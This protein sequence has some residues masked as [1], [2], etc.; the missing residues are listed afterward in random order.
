[1]SNK[2]D[3][4]NQAI[5]IRSTVRIVYKDYHGQETERS[6]EPLEWVTH[7]RIRA[8][9][10][11]RGEERDFRID[12]IVECALV[13]TGQSQRT[14][15]NKTTSA[16]ADQRETLQPVVHKVKPTDTRKEPARSRKRLGDQPIAQVR[17]ADQWSRLVK[18]YVECLVRENQ[19]QYIIEDRRGACFFFPAKPETVRD[20][21]EGRVFLEF[22]SGQPSHPTPVARFVN[23]DAGRQGQ[24]LCLGYPVLVLNDEKIAPLI[25]APVE[26]QESNGKLR[27]QAQDPEPSYAVFRNQGLSAEEIEAVLTAYAAIGSER[28]QFQVEAWENL[29][30]GQISQMTG[31]A[32]RRRSWNG[33][34]PVP[35]EPGTLCDAPLLFWVKDNVATR[36]LIRE[37]RDLSAHGKWESAPWALRELLS[38]V[39]EKEYPD[40]PAPRDDNNVYVAEANDRQRQA[41]TAAWSTR[42]TVVTG[43]PGTGKSQMVLNLIAQAV[44]GD[45]SV[46]FAS[47]NNKAVDV[48]MDRLKNEIRFPGAVRT[49]NTSNRQKAAEDMALV[50][51]RISVAGKPSSVAPLREQ[52]LELGK[53]LADAAETLHQVRELGGLLD[54]HLAERDDLI[55]LLPKPVAEVAQSHPPKYQREEIHHLRMVISNLLTTALKIRDEAARLEGDIVR[56]VKQNHLR[57]PILD[58]LA[59]FEDQWG[60]F[61][62][63]FLD[64]RELDTLEAIQDY[65]QTWL[66]LL[67]ALEAQGQITQL[68]HRFRELSSS[69]SQRQSELHIELQDQVEIAASRVENRALDSFVAE[70]RR[71]CERSAAIAR[72]DLSLWDKLL[73]WVGLK[74]PVRE[75]GERFLAL[76]DAFGLDWK[77]ST[78]RKAPRLA[79]VATACYQLAVFSVACQLKSRAYD[80]R[81]AL[82]KKRQ[83]LEEITASLPPALREDVGKVDLPHEGADAL[84]K[85]ISAILDRTDALIKERDQLAARV[86][87]KLDSNDDTLQTLEEFKS[88]PAGKDKYLWTLRVPIKLPV[89][90]SH[91]DKWRHLVSL[92]ETSQ[93]IRHLERQRKTLPAER[94][95]LA[96]VRDLQ[97][98]QFELGAKIITARWLERVKGLDTRTLQKARDYVSAVQQLSLGHVPYY[99]DLKSAEEANLPAALEIFPVW[100]TTNLSA[101][102]NLPLSPDLFDIVVIDEASQC[103]V[104]SALPLLY[105]A[106]HLMIIGDPSQLKHVATLY[107]RSDVEAAIEFG[108]APDA[109]LY[110]THSLFDISQ[111]SVA[112]RPGAILLREHYRS[113]AQIIGFSNE[114]F[115]GRQLVVLT[116]MERRGVPPGFLRDG[117]GAFWVHADGRAEHPP[118]GSA[119]NLAELE[120]LQDLVP[121]L[122]EKL[123]QYETGDFRFTLGIVTPYRE[124]ANRIQDWVSQRYGNKS[125]ILVG[126]AHTFQGDERDIVIFSPVLGPGLSEGSLKWL[127]RTKNL[128][129]VAITRA[130]LQL[131]VLGNWDYCHGLPPSSVYRRLASYLGDQ[132]VR[133]PNQLAVLSGEPQIDVIGTRVDGSKPQHNRITLRRFVTSCT[134]FVWWVDR[135]LYDHVF[136]LLWDVFQQPSVD[137]RDVRL[138]TSVEQAQASK[139]QGPKIHRDKAKALQRELHRRGVNFEIRFLPKNDLPHDRFFY[140]RGKSVNMPPFGSAYGDHKH[141]SEY[142]RS[143]TEPTFFEQYWKQAQADW[144]TP[145][146]R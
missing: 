48:V 77:P 79:R 102:T 39:P 57:C 143:A 87:A 100:A 134:Q 14:H 10:H 23:Q 43:P 67:P 108:V 88:T 96:R 58:A 115:Y 52:Y 20:L 44:M 106:K 29:L 130:R 136:D 38:S 113:H 114:E 27:L 41:I 47:R 94:E 131:I 118:G 139:S 127:D 119:F 93:A 13:D 117:C 128:L 123:A 22:P 65:V 60:S 54:S 4:I 110:N 37:L 62:G 28:G 68:A 92:W 35:L 55:V 9:C 74:D 30:V 72:G 104:P 141:V 99:A 51:D 82:K 132:M 33:S 95:A 70:A 5:S 103:D 142:T 36:N 8:F 146:V 112:L 15:A 133:D 120:A 16:Q 86:N 45:R 6:I 49:G 116:D 17:T 121:R 53:Q 3:L 105:R 25:F 89:I 31:D 138:L 81:D 12:R 69:C 63:G 66:A 126:T 64:Q 144:G 71:L 83:R 101:R 34:G 19:Q 73:A 75:I 24:H 21:L 76:R 1:M 42:V 85:A 56:I 26:S 40:A 18:Y 109:F 124:Q 129:N 7:N 32:L 140:S 91:L 90:I 135:Y 2:H 46:L 11:L 107:E 98:K 59:Q 122:L 50:L 111:R 84:G 78:S 61:G 125:Q 137:I 80:T 97:D 145:G